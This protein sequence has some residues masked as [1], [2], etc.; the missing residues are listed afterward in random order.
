MACC[1][2]R[3]AL[4]LAAVVVAVAAA[5]LASAGWLPMPVPE[6]CAV[7]EGQTVCVG[8]GL[9][10]DDF[11]VSAQS[12]GIEL[13][14]TVAPFLQAECLDS[15]GQAYHCLGRDRA[16]MECQGEADVLIGQ[17]AHDCVEVVGQTLE[18]YCIETA[19]PLAFGPGNEVCYRHYTYRHGEGRSLT[20]ERCVQA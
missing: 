3:H 5:P 10:G 17:P 15:R 11:C 20:E 1:H 14:A 7:A 2:P 9:R 18:E 4:L 6:R 13:V 8:Q 12:P 16:T 19:G